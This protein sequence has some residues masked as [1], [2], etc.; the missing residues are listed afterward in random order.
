MSGARQR[1]AVRQLCSK[2]RSE[3][4]RRSEIQGVP[5]YVYEAVMALAEAVEKLADVSED[6][7]GKA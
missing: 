5:A 2:A 3:I 1:E 7:D 4:Q 6:G